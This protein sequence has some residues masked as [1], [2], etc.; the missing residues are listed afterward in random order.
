MSLRLRYLN[1]WSPVGGADWEDLGGVSLLEEYVI[2]AGLW[3]FIVLNY[4]HLSL[5][6]L[7]LNLKVRA[8]SFFLQPPYLLLVAAPY[9]FDELIS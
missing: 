9:C 7:Y 4:V 1:T 6:A 3:V 2:G 8:L 5:S